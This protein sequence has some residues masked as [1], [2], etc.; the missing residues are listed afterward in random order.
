M[1]G[2]PGGLSDDLLSLLPAL[3]DGCRNARRCRL[4]QTVAGMS[5]AA[6]SAGRV[7]KLSCR[8]ARR[9][10]LSQLCCRN[11]RCCRLSQTVERCK[12]FESKVL[13]YCFEK[14]FDRGR[15]ALMLI[16]QI[17]NLGSC[18][19]EFL[20]SSFRC[21]LI[22]DAFF[23]TI[24]LKVALLTEYHA[25]NHIECL[26]QFSIYLLQKAKTKI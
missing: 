3:S 24:M 17:R 4:S 14:I 10:R 22:D 9:C 25:S 1:C 11:A 16:P 6:G 21:F 5:G 26:H 12:I 2:N 8:H 15:S 20:Q 18:F 13:P 19:V 23:L 7:R